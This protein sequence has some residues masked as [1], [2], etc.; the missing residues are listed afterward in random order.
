MTSERW[1]QLV[2]ERE[3]NRRVVVHD[4]GSQPSMYDLRIGTVEAPEVAIE[5]VRA[6]DPV[7]TETWNVGPGKG[8]LHLAVKGDWRIIMARDARISTLR[9]RLEPFLCDL[10]GTGCPSRE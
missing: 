1:A 5:C 7:G 4:D 8:P 9:Q 3:L 10:G 2:I 6:V